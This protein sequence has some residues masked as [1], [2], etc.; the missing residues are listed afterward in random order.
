LNKKERKR[1]KE[2]NLSIERATIIMEDLN[3]FTGEAGKA[4]IAQAQE[5][6]SRDEVWFYSGA[7]KKMS[8]AK[9]LPKKTPAEKEIRSDAI[10]NARVKKRAAKLIA[11]YGE[12][13]ILAPDESLKE[14]IINR[15]VKGF[16]ASIQQ[17][18]E[19]NEY[20]KMASI[21]SQAT[22]PY[23]DAKALLI[24]AEYYTHYEELQERYFELV[25]V[26]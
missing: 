19:L 9:K 21:Y 18:Q 16:L 1:A 12:E 4:R 25:S 10:K 22:K 8:L 15:D 2:R 14:E 26:Q 11:K 5:D 17:K 20:L 24:Q 6:L 7:Y 13:N 23:N 3:K